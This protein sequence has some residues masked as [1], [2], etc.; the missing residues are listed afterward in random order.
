MGAMMYFFQDALYLFCRKNT[1]GGRAICWILFRPSFGSG[2]K[3]PAVILLVLM[4]AAFSLL[5]FF[6]PKSPLSRDP[7][8]G[9]YQGK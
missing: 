7:R 5:T 2:F 4:I 1:A 9:Q 6:P 3:T 8:T